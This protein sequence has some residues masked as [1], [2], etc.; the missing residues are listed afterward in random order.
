M[1]L[2]SATCSLPPLSSSFRIHTLQPKDRPLRHGYSWDI[3]DL[4]SDNTS[5]RAVDYDCNAYTAVVNTLDFKKV[6]VITAVKVVEDPCRTNF[7]PAIWNANG[8]ALNT[9]GRWSFWY[10]ME[11]MAGNNDPSEFILKML[12]TF[13]TTTIVNGFELDDRPGWLGQVINR[14]RSDSNCPAYVGL[15]DDCSL[16]PAFAPFRLAAIVNRMDLRPNAGS[17]LQGGPYGNGI[18]E[19]TAGE[20]RFVFQV[21]GNGSPKNASII[22]EYALPTTVKDRIDW[23]NDWLSLNLLDWNVPDGGPLSFRTKLQ[24][25]TDAFVTQDI[26]PGRPNLGSAINTVRTNERSFDF[27]FSELNK[28]WSLRQFEL[29][30]D[31]GGCSVD[32]NFLIPT[33]VSMTPDSSAGTSFNEQPRDVDHLLPFINQERIAIRNG[34]HTVPLS[35]NGVDFLGGESMSNASD[36][37]PVF[38]GLGIFDQ[39]DDPAT[40]LETRHLFALATCNGCHYAET[41]NT[42]NMHIGVKHLGL[43]APLS[44]FLL[45]YFQTS[46]QLDMAGT[47]FAEFNEPERRMCELRHTQ[48]GAATKLSTFFGG[49]H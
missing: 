16:D 22:L 3:A 46:V 40:A 1:S 19:D 6:G 45:G 5:F 29:G 14:W 23:A 21:L 2:H 28:Q 7:D 31:A 33:P 36:A 9:R 27:G 17:N 41:E 12:E 38:W 32:E 42:A 8:C 39:I 49:A 26:F 48:T 15:T 13:H 47:E 4:T 24:S 43:E 18:D 34:E 35:F 44:N 10:L 25:I 11:Q 37:Q 20:G 30:C